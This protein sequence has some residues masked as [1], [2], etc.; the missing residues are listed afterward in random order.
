MSGAWA[1]QFRHLSSKEVGLL[2]FVLDSVV[3]NKYIHIQIHQFKCFEFVV[4]K[5]FKI[6]KSKSL[7]EIEVKVIEKL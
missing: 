7:I 6:Y 3:A 1:P 2:Q 5:K 4:L